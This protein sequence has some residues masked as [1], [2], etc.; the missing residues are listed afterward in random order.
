[1]DVDDYDA[2]MMEENEDFISP[3]PSGEDFFDE[4]SGGQRLA[5]QRIVDKNFFNDFPDLFDEDL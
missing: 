4:K 1:M 2:I 5:P 3:S